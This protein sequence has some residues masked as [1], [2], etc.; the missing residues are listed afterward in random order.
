MRKQ[1]IDL[2][3]E[4]SPLAPSHVSL[5]SKVTRPLRQETNRRK[6]TLDTSENIVKVTEKGETG[7]AEY[8]TVNMKERSE[9]QKALREP[10][11]RFLT[12]G[13]REEEKVI[14]WEDRVKPNRPARL[15]SSKG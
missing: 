13:D 8:L 1:E 5:Q 7:T 12:M 14:R 6:Q 15:H 3:E 9:I 2:S 4:L 10:E 11:E